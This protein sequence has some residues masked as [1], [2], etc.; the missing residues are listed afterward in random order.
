MNARQA[1]LSTINQK[2]TKPVISSSDPFDSVADFE[3]DRSSKPST[4]AS[5]R[6]GFSAANA[7]YRNEFR[8][9]GGIENQSVQELEN[10]AVYKAEET[11][12]TL[13]GCLKI[14]EE[15]REDASNTLVKLHQQGQQITRTHQAVADIEHDLS[16]V[17]YLFV[18]FVLFPFCVELSRIIFN[19]TSSI[20]LNRKI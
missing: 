20:D 17:C 3:V 1:L 4:S 14:A 7:R 10:Y 2:R 11:T 16:R 8:D 19:Q 12:N 9:S 6:L 15:M 13:N 5:S 18:S